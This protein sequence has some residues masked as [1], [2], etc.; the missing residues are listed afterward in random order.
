VRPRVK[1]LL[2]YTSN[3]SELCGLACEGGGVEASVA[4]QLE[5][6]SNDDVTLL[7]SEVVMSPVSTCDDAAEGCVN[8]AFTADIV[9]DRATS[10]QQ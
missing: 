10:R 2:V 3:L 6:S 4:E 5:L 7:W 9:D 1:G 8:A